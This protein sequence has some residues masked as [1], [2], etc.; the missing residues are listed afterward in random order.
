VS[1]VE[2]LNKEYSSASKAPRTSI[3]SLDSIR[4]QQSKLLDSLT[5]FRNLETCRA[6][7]LEHIKNFEKRIV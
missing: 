2:L 4:N 7:V 5:K 1:K 6:T 3:Y